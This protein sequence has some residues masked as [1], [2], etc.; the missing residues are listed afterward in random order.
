MP[1]A[2]RQTQTRTLS[3]L[4]AILD[5]WRN[6]SVYLDAGRLHEEE[7]IELRGRRKGVF[8]SEAGTSVILQKTRRF[9]F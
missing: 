4:P 8:G 7:A 9:E 1:V 3:A 5:R 2:R 6:Q